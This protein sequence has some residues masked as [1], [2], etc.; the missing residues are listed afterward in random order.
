MTGIPGYGFFA[1]LFIIGVL[2]GI[3][4]GVVFTNLRENADSVKCPI[5]QGEG[6]ID[7]YD[8]NYPG[9]F[10]RV[11]CREC[12]GQRRIKKEL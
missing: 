2:V 1:T 7:A 9:T 6:A 8:S 12:N 4:V 3:I 10:R 11:I 5:C